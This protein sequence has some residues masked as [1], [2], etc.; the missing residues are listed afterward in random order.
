M[1][2]SYDQTN[3][4]LMARIQN[5]TSFNYGCTQVLID[6][7]GTNATQFWNSNTANY[8]MNKTFHVLPATNNASGSY[9]LTLYY[10]QAEVQGWQTLTGQ[11]LA[12]IQ[13]VKVPGQISMVTAANPNGAGSVTVV[14]PTIGSLGSNTSLTYTSTNGFS[15]FGAGIP[16]FSDLPIGLIQFSGRLE[17]NSAVLTWSTSYEQNNKGFEVDRSMDGMNFSKIGF[18]TG[19]G[20]S[21]TQKDYTFT[22]PSLTGDSDYYQLKQIDLD[23][24]ITYSNV[25]LL[26]D[27]HSAVPYMTVLP[28]PFTTDLDILFGHV[29]TEKVQVRLLNIAGQE[30]WR[31]TGIQSDGSRLHIGLS[32][33]SLSAGIYLLEVLSG[34]GTTI[35]RVVRK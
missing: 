8:L 28:N 26:N 33:A 7:A 4:L 13:L 12:A 5:L 15:G 3:G 32:G 1:S 31:Q 27:A 22:D 11:S 20:N 14:T 19:A 6:R 29:R 35:Q 18:V 16:S 9:N 2:I 23:G 25:V 34:S 21:A 10:T 17:G 30:L 24:R